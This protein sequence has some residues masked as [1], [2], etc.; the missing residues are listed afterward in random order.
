MHDH[1]LLVCWWRNPKSI[2]DF[3][4]VYHWLEQ[5]LVQ[6]LYENSVPLSIIQGTLV[7]D[8]VLEP[9][10][11]YEVFWWREALPEYL[12]IKKTVDSS[13]LTSSWCW[14]AQTIWHDAAYP[15]TSAPTADSSTATLS[16]MLLPE[17]GGFPPWCSSSHCLGIKHTR[18]YTSCRSPHPLSLKLSW[19]HLARFCSEI[20]ILILPIH[21]IIFGWS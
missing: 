20:F 21:S 16:Q 15:E 5:Q 8:L 9:K 12:K 11:V 10:G 14:L 17:S 2:D 4:L 1:Y 3:W 7:Q 18:T 13:K 19:V 6:P